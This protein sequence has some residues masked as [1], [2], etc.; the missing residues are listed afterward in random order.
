MEAALRKDGMDCVPDTLYA[1]LHATTRSKMWKRTI[2][3]RVVRY[4]MHAGTLAGREDGAAAQA[5][6][7]T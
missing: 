1:N 3:L 4:E 5:P 2:L 7:A 6:F